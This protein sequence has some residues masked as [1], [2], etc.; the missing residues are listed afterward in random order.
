MSFKPT[1]LFVV[2]QVK[3][4]KNLW[5]CINTPPDSKYEFA[6]LDDMFDFPFR[7]KK[8][9][10]IQKNI[11]NIYIELFS[12]HILPKIEKEPDLSYLVTVTNKN[13]VMSIYVFFRESNLLPLVK[14]I[15]GVNV[16]KIVELIRSR[17]S[18]KRFYRKRL[19]IN[20]FV[21]YG[22][23][24]RSVSFTLIYLFYLCHR[25]D[26]IIEA[27]DNSN[28]IVANHLTDKIN[29]K[30]ERILQI[31][32]IDNLINMLSEMV[33]NNKYEIEMLFSEEIMAVEVTSYKEEG[34][35][36]YVPGLKIFNYYNRKA[37]E[38]ISSFYGKFFPKNSL[39]INI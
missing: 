21:E 35:K 7:T 13:D 34:R 4:L 6:A 17:N 1:K 32:T 2:A 5:N 14:K 24:W 25:T 28:S 11:K 31:C 39:Q 33:N 30:P 16:F 12:N 26:L 23:L 10:E 15:N 9:K 29:L 3:T 36:L 27:I 18:S 20:S 38:I 22:S 8:E 37:T 19:T